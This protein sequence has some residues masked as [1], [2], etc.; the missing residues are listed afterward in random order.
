VRGRRQAAAGALRGATRAVGGHSD[1]HVTVY[2]PAGTRVGTAELGRFRSWAHGLDVRD[3]PDLLFVQGD[4][5]E[6]RVVVAVDPPGTVRRLFPVAWDGDVDADVRIGCGV[7]V[8]GT[9]VHAALRIEDSVLLPG[10][11]VVVR[12]G[13]P[14]GG[15]LWLFRADHQ[16]TA[17]DV[18]GGRVFVALNTGDVFVLDL[19]DGSVLGRSGLTVGGHRVLPW[20]LSRSGVGRVA[21]GTADGRVL[22]CSVT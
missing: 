6:T 9:L 14:G 8:D 19:A 16:V 5:T 22:D 7:Y 20:S 18:A 21:I 17:L 12:R 1:G 13:Y 2:D 4:D 3:A 11:G 10:N 15:P